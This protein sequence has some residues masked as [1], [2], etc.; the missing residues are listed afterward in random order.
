MSLNKYRILL[1]ILFALI[2][3]SLFGCGGDSSGGE[4]GP[5]ISTPEPD[6]PPVGE[7][8]SQPSQQ[9][10]P[11]SGLPPTP[12]LA[13][14][15]TPSLAASPTPRPLA[16]VTFNSINVRTGPGMRNSSIG[17]LYKGDIVEILEQNDDVTWYRIEFKNRTDVWI[18]SS[19]VEIIN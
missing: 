16:R 10:E 1:L 18:A 11:G 15:P 7:T 14:P 4:E 19:V 12:S 13:P 9:E 8:P 5:A 6:S 3:A 2:A 17:F